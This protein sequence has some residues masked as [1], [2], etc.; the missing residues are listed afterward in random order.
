MST[1]VVLFIFNRPLLTRFTWEAVKQEAPRHLVIVADGPRS[2]SK[3]DERLVHETRD[4]VNDV[5]WD[6]HV[7]RLYASKNLGLRLRFESALD[8]IFTMYDKIIVLED[9]CI[10]SPSFFRFTESLLNA[11]ENEPS[12]GLI[13][14]HNFSARGVKPEFFFDRN[15]YVWGWASWRRVWEAYRAAS[16]RYAARLPLSELEGKFEHFL[17]KHMTLRLFR[18]MPQLNTWDVPFSFFLREKNYL[19]ATPKTNL[20]AN[21]GFGKN[22]TNPSSKFGRAELPPSDIEFEF[23]DRPLAVDRKSIRKMWNRRLAQILV[24][25]LKHPDVAMNLLARSLREIL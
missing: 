24:F 2:Q 18:L 16:P 6:C 21:F 15:S 20:V 14:G 8:E 3:D 10:P 12:V 7:T 9:D 17:E 25:S 23:G 1:A 4:V 22:A 11:Y 5:T 13:S 19:N